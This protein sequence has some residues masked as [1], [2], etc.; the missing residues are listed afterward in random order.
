MGT[1]MAI[2]NTALT[3]SELAQHYDLSK[4]HRARPKRIEDLPETAKC[5]SEYIAVTLAE[6]EIIIDL[7]RQRTEEIYCQW[8]ESSQEAVGAVEIPSGQYV[9]LNEYDIDEKPISEECGQ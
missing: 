6:G 4:L 8:C 3:L 2:Q 7:S 1:V 5:C 9:V